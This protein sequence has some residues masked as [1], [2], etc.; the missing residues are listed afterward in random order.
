MS[1][2]TVT[3]QVE[4]NYSQEDLQKALQTIWTPQEMSFITLTIAKGLVEIHREAMKA[5]ADGQLY[6]KAHEEVT[7]LELVGSGA[8]AKLFAAIPPEHQER[9]ATVVHK[10][11]GMEIKV[12]EMRRNT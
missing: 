5:K 9:M 10:I 12:N 2:Q 11:T 7:K 6:G 1:K 8:F 4:S 3:G